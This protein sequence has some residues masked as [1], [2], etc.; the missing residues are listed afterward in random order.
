[1]NTRTHRRPT[2]TFLYLEN[3]YL[4]TTS[5]QPA[6]FTCIEKETT[7]ELRDGISNG[8]PTLPRAYGGCGNWRGAFRNSL[9]LY[10]VTFPEGLRI[11][12]AAAFDDC[13]FLSELEFPES[14]KYI[15]LGAFASRD[16]FH[17]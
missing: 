17:L 2:L 6:S 16:S 14:L 15:G 9:E 10:G 12:N 5:S 13:L 4:N 3:T 11:I 7:T 1:M 8:R